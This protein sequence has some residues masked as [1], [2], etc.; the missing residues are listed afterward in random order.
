[1]LIVSEYMALSTSPI[2]IPSSY[3]LNNK[4][5]ASWCGLNQNRRKPWR[6]KGVNAEL[7]SRIFSAIFPQ[8]L[9]SSKSS[10]KK[11]SKKPY[12]ANA[13]ADSSQTPFW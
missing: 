1:M 9:P 2:F 7:A 8:R 12:T 13:A 3:V 5:A 10:L 11:I 4:S 6:T